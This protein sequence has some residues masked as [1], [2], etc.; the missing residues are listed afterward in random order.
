MWQ[1]IMDAGYSYKLYGKDKLRALVDKLTG[2][3]VLIYSV[4]TDLLI[5]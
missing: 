1:F 3:I 2:G 4:D 5:F